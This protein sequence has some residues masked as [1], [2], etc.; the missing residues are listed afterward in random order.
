MRR[1]AG[2]NARATA[3]RSRVSTKVAS[4]PKRDRTCCRS[5][6]V[7][8]YSARE[9]STWSPVLSRA[10]KSA[11]SAASPVAKATAGGASSRCPR[12]TSRADTVGLETRE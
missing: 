6:V 10:W 12:A 5:R 7:P 9:A 11:V 8:P 2:R 1:V 4:M 3:A